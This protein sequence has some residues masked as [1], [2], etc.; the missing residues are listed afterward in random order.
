MTKRKPCKAWKRNPHGM[1]GWTGLLVLDGW[2][3]VETEQAKADPRVLLRVEDEVRRELR[4][5]AKMLGMRV[6]ARKARK[7]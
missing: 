2:R 7:P 1:T 6:V 3:V 4:A 5:A